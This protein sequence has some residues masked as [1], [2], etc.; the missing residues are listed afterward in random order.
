[1]TKGHFM[2]RKF[3]EHFSRALVL[4]L[5][6]LPVAMG[7]EPLSLAGERPDGVPALLEEGRRAIV[8]RLHYRD[9]KW[10]PVFR[11]RISR[12]QRRALGIQEKMEL[13]I[14]YFQLAAINVER[15]YGMGLT[16]RFRFEKNE[17]EYRRNID[18][19]NQTVRW[20]IDNPNLPP[21][22]RALA[23]LILGGTA[24]YIGKYEFGVGNP[25]KAFT[26]G[27]MADRYLEKALALDP[28]LVDAH[29][30][31]GM[32]RYVNSRLGGIGNFLMQGGR[33]RRQEGFSHLIR[34]VNAQPFAKPVAYQALILF[35]I[36]EQLNEKNRNLPASHPLSPETCR[37]NTGKWIG[38]FENRYFK[39]EAPDG[40]FI[41]N[42]T[43]EVMKAAHYSINGDYARARE[44]YGN[45]LRIM[46]FLREK[47][48]YRFNP[49]L[50]RTVEAGI[51]FCDL[52]LLRPSAGRNPP[53]CERIRRG[54]EFVN[55]GEMMIESD[56]VHLG[57]DLRGVYRRKLADVSRDRACG[58]P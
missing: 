34:A 54:L 35:Y 22:Q 46:T 45:A 8:D 15:V 40:G 10:M 30:G 39:N 12:L 24:G 38:E 13:T 19:A 17:A 11:D 21:R 14:S 56:F 42:K 4:A 18:K 2:M 9:E 26:N 16:R 1:M 53:V 49:R 55:S 41:G 57:N 7:D 43:L 3:R 5:F 50:I 27:F 37:A 52:M 36:S 25:L 44:A 29:I 48:G 6:A 20:L 32:Y 31:L 58:D 51:E 33:D 47:R 28:Q 23:Y